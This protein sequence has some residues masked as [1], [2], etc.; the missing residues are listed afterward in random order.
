MPVNVFSNPDFIGKVYYGRKNKLKVLSDVPKH[1][2]LKKSL[3]EMYE[4]T[5]AK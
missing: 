2:L 4:M 1:I 3:C 5:G